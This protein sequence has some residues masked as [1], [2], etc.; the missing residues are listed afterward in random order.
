MKKILL[1]VFLLF[2]SSIFSQVPAPECGQERWDVK[3]LTDN[4]APQIELDN[5]YLLLCMNKLS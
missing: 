1:I 2:R 4:Q 3:T 5:P